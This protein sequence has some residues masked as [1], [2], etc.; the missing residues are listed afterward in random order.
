MLRS[1]RA[2]MIQRTQGSAFRHEVARLQGI[3]CACLREIFRVSGRP[4][5]EI[6]HRVNASDTGYVFRVFACPAIKH[7]AAATLRE[8]AR[9]TRQTIL[10]DQ[11]R[12]KSLINIAT[13]L[14]PIRLADINSGDGNA[15]MDQLLNHPPVCFPRQWFGI[16]SR[17]KPYPLRG[18]R[19]LENKA[20]MPIDHH[21]DPLNAWNLERRA[22]A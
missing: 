16:K 15:A 5:G 1:N 9:L 13:S 14:T 17:R 3:G 8:Q 10:R 7:Q 21:R 11:S 4:T 20:A 6:Q 19:W 2:K 18:M 22:W 12:V